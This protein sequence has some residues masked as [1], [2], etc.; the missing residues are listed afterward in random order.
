MMLAETKSKS[1]SLALSGMPKTAFPPVFVR[2]VDETRTLTTITGGLQIGNLGR[3]HH[4]FLRFQIQIKGCGQ[5]HLAVRFV[6]LDMIR[7]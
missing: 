2:T 3:A 7:T 1:P 6:M 5:V 4:H